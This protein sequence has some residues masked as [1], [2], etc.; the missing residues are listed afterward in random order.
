M[1]PKY[2]V[3]FENIVE[4]MEIEPGKNNKS[5]EYMTDEECFEQAKKNDA[6]LD[7]IL[8]LINQKS[9]SEGPD[10]QKWINEND[11]LETK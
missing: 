7:K 11:V 6:K 5:G 2:T 10:K 3:T 1:S 9:N 4:A 8:A